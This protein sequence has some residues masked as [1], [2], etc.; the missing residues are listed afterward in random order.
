MTRWRVTA[1]YVT[2]H[3]VS[4]A[5]RVPGRGFTVLPVVGLH[6]GNVLPADVPFAD[7]AHLLSTGQIEAISEGEGQ[8]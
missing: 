2:V 5:P 7:I 6:A 4:A 1:P 3:S 8:P